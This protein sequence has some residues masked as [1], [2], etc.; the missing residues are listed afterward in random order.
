MALTGDAKAA[1]RPCLERIT[2]PRRETS[3]SLSLLEIK[4]AGDLPAAIGAL[5]QATAAGEIAP[6]EKLSGLPA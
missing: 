5:L 1:L 6:P 4:A 3:V 2:P